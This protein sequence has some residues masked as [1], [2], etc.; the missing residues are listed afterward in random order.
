M[1]VQGLGLRVSGLGLRCAFFESHR[2]SVPHHPHPVMESMLQLGVLLYIYAQHE[3]RNTR[4]LEHPWRIRISGSS[5]SGAA[6]SVFCR[7]L[8]WHSFQRNR[9]IDEEPIM[10]SR[11]NFE[12]SP[13]RASSSTFRCCPWSIEA[14][15]ESCRPLGHPCF[16]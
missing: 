4:S 9:K 16:N 15:S 13:L 10:C 8:W 7:G 2:S 1:R 3:Y 12:I 5:P 11:K 6:V 14:A